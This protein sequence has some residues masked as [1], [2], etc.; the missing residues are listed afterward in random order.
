MGILDWSI[1]GAYVVVAMV[2][3]VWFTRRASRSTADFF[4]AGRTLPWFIAGTSIVATT[5]SS[6]TPL[7]VAGMS[8]RDGIASNWFWWS[9]AIGMT[10]TVYFF[11]RLW[12]RSEIVTDLEFVVLRY[13]NSP[14]TALLRVFKVFTDGVLF[15][16]VVVASV[17]GAMAKVM[18]VMLDL[19][20]GV[21]FVL[22]IV[23]D[24]TWVTVL[25][26]GLATLALVYSTLSGLYGVVYTD[27]IQ[28][29]LAMIGSFALAG[30][31]YYRASTGDEAMM[32]TLAN[33]E[34][35]K[36][37]LL[38]FIPSFETFDL[39]AFTF[40]AY[41]SVIWWSSAPGSGYSV[42][43][44]L[45]TRSERDSALAFLWYCFCHIVL[46]PWPWIIVGMLS[47]IY[48]PD[49]QG[50]DAELAY[51]MM[52]KEFLPVG[53]KGILV[54]SLL[55]AFMSTLDTHLNWGASYL[56]NDLYRP[57]LVRDRSEHHYVHA[58][59]IAMVVLIVLAVILSTLIPSILAA[60]KYLGVVFG[61]IGTVMI[62]RWYW[63]RVN[64]WAEL[65]AL[66]SCLA[67]GNFMI[68]KF[69]DT[70]E[71]NMY[72]VQIVV[73][74]ATVAATWLLVAFVT[75]SAP[76]DADRAFYEKIR[77]AGPGWKR[78]AT[79][80]GLQPLPGEFGR[81]LIGWIV[82]CTAL[83]S[84]LIGSGKLLFHQWTTGGILMA[85]GIIASI[86]TLKIF[87]HGLHDDGT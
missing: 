77:V 17:A 51:P 9:S 68:W 44:V 19:P 84:V 3:G 37:D 45:A 70:E 16:C 57:Y 80:T 82:C 13:G 28:F 65:T 21:L 24:V 20:T 40:V 60:Y 15:N 29:G 31:V 76:S 32:A 34:G 33:T 26:V 7:F 63:W 25:L 79:E 27:L 38:R 71:A 46:R 47:L 72:G 41:V 83:F 59:R 5:F 53:L 81:S 18:T 49:L 66:A 10:A 67:I 69:P 8:R 62:L 22:P 12:R 61:G 6:D 4:V 58:S 86:V 54:A 56:V 42:Q 2:I 85:I 39:A 74:I 1:V 14:E 11:A 78:V 75:K 48:Y 55:A 87:P 30:I 73:T 23:G 52:I 50:P 43:R 64:A 36:D 35:F